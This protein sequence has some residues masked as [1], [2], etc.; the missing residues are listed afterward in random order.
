MEAEGLIAH[1]VL[2]V[3][4][5]I[6]GSVPSVLLWQRA[7]EPDAGRWA[8]PGGRL[9]GEE[10]VEARC[11]ATSPR[12]STS[13]RSP[14]SSSSRCS[15]TRTAARPAPGGHGVPRARA[16]RRRPGDP[17]RHRVVPGRRPAA[18]RLRPRRDHPRRPRPAARQALVHQHRVRA[19]P[20]RSSRS[21]SCATSTRA[22]LGHHVSAT[23]LQRVLTRRGVL[24]PTGTTAAP[25]PCGRAA[26]GAVPVRRARTAG[27]RPVRRAAPAAGPGPPDAP[28][29]PLV[30]RLVHPA[31][32][33]RRAVA[34]WPCS[35]RCPSSR[36]GT[37]LLPGA[38]LPLHV[39]EPRYRQLTIDLVTGA[40]AGKQFGVVA[41][42]EGWGPDDG[43]GG[44]HESGC[45]A[46]AARGP[47]PARRPVRHPDRRRAPLPAARRGRH[48]RALPRRQRRVAPR[49]RGRR[50]RG[51][52]ARSSGPPAPRTVATAPPPGTPAAGATPRPASRPTREVGRR[53]R[54]RGRGPAVARRRGRAASTPRC[55]PTCSRPTACCP[56]AT[57][58][59]SSSR[60]ARRAPADGLA[61]DVPRGRAARRLHAVWAPTA[62]FAVPSSDN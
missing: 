8:L 13:P 15:P 7:R 41:V 58:R 44:L 27:D 55:W 45:T 33:G 56:S 20:R 38:P 26:R 49:P 60:P 14:T 54:A 47:A 31:I 36:L 18:D 29:Y 30:H 21:P 12:R 19:R 23:N 11:A 42:R 34:W 1:D 32:E 3:V 22:A 24:V 35:R 59:T 25:G 4:L 5:R 2:A 43:R 46:R 39:F 48:R 10:D 37:V 61:L 28:A 17:R 62:K 40:V 50:P 16:L 6:T 53:D 57:A 9:G 51:P 52:G